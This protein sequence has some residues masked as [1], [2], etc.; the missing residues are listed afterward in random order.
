M[1]V[2]KRIEELGL[3]LPEAPSAGGIY[4]PVK[5]FS[6]KMLYTS[7]IGPF[8]DGAPLMVGK[9]G[10]ELSVEQGQEAARVTILNM[11]S[12]IEAK[13][14]DL[15]KIK[16]FIKVLGFVAGTDDFYQQ[17]QVMNGASQLLVDIFG[18]KTGKAARSAIG[19]NALPGNI[20]V[21]IEAVIELK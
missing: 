11:L 18:E 17:P 7:G 19:T 16:S 9:L 5:R 2:Y 1:D 14:G 6:D 20:P 12:V 10:S 3:K 8:K 4:Y 21:E 15:N 13:I